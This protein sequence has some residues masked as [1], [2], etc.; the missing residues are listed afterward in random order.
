MRLSFFGNRTRPKPAGSPP[1]HAN[2]SAEPPKQT[3]HS[4][5]KIDKGEMRSIEEITSTK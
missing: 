1:E 2:R 5:I 3:D 4:Q